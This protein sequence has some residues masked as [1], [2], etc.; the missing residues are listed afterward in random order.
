MSAGRPRKPATQRKDHIIRVSEYEIGLIYDWFQ[1]YKSHNKDQ[2][3]FKDAEKLWKRIEETPVV[4]D[5][6]VKLIN[7]TGIEGKK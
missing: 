6:G 2:L 4:I 1:E 7:T 5:K 3:A